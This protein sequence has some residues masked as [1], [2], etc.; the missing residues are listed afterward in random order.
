MLNHIDAQCIFCADHP[1]RYI[2]YLI[3]LKLSALPQ[4][5]E[6]DYFEAEE[7]DEIQ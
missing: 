5:W 2:I 3:S 1:L 7:A 6:L 4:T